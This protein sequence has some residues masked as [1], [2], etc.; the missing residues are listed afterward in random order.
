MILFF[1]SSCMKMLFRQIF[2]IPTFGSAVNVIFVLFQLHGNRGVKAGYHIYHGVKVKFKFFMHSVQS[3]LTF[4]DPTFF[5]AQV[6][7]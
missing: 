3:S 6:Y 1:S 4:Q 5:G 7:S 2:V